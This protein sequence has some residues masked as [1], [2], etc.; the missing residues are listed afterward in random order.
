MAIYNYVITRIRNTES[1]RFKCQLRNSAQFYHM[2]RLSYEFFSKN[3]SQIR[4]IFS[5]LNDCKKKI[6]IYDFCYFS[7]TKLVSKFFYDKTCIKILDLNAENLN[8]CTTKKRKIFK[9]I[10]VL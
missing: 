7:T 3:K 1:L 5:T 2:Y 9:N 6:L 10:E 4:P 8:Y